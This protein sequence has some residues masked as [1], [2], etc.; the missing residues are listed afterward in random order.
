MKRQTRDQCAQQLSIHGLC[1]ETGTRPQPWGTEQPCCGSQAPAALKL[2]DMHGFGVLQN[3]Y[4]VDMD[5]NIQIQW[6]KHGHPII[7]VYEYSVK[8]HRYVPWDLDQVA[9]DRDMTVVIS[10]GQHFR[11]F[12]LELF[13]QRMLNVRAAIQRLLQRSP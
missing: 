6:K 12:P 9:G 11:P 4:A 7:T 3:L 5:R 1:G 8:D 10:L 2:F 13:L